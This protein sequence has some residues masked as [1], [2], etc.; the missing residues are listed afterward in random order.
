MNIK[1]SVGKRIQKER[2]GKDI[3]QEGLAEAAKL[4]TSYIAKV[5]RGEIN[6]GLTNLYKICRALDIKMVDLLSGY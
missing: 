4:N 1:Q 2:F 3:T 6:I 5:E